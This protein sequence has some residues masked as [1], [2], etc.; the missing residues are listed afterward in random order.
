MSPE[1]SCVLFFA[2]LLFVATGRTLWTEVM[3][4]LLMLNVVLDFLSCQISPYKELS[5]FKKEKKSRLS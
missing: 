3:T 4:R 5:F 2:A 1:T